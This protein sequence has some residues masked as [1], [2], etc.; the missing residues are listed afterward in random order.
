MPAIIIWILH[1]LYNRRV[2][3]HRIVL[4]ITKNK[5]IKIDW[6]LSR[7]EFEE[8]LKILKPKK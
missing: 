6:H 1:W 4:W 8:Y 7:K 2:T 5:K 3:I